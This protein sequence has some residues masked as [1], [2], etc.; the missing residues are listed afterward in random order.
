QISAADEALQGRRAQRR[1]PVEAG[2]AQILVD[3]RLRD[4]AA[5]ADQ[6]DMVD[7]EATLQLGDLISK[8]RGIAGVAFGAAL[9]KHKM[10]KHF[11]LTISDDRFAF[12]RKSEQIAQEAAL[13]G[14]YAVRTS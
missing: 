9:D 7:G 12:A 4:H 2:G 5:I 3:A 14:L 10:A 6:H 8:G 11:D 1:D 13:D